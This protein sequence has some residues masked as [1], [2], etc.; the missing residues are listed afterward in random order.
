ML[1]IIYML[2]SYKYKRHEPLLYETSNS[3]TRNKKSIKRCLECI[4]GMIIPDIYTRSESESRSWRYTLC[5]KAYQSLAAGRWFSPGTP[6]SSAN[7][8]DRHNITEILVSM[9]LNTITH[10]PKSARSWLLNIH[11]IISNIHK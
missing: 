6:V 9:A 1:I 11:C 3:N 7:K 2:H 5:D 8:T 10:S 4:Q